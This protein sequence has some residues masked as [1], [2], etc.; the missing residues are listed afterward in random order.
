MILL[1]YRPFD[2]EV[3]DH[4]ITGDALRDME[5]II[6]KS[7]ADLV[8]VPAWGND[9]QIRDVDKTN[10][11]GSIAERIVRVSKVPVMIIK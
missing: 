1:N 2:I 4:L 6:R 8:V 5:T 9:T 3:T 7:K 11:I 10:F